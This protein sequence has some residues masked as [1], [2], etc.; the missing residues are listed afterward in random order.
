MT[1]YHTVGKPVIRKDATAKVL[2]EAVYT[3]DIKLPGLLHGK[4]LRSSYPHALIK[5]INTE[6]AK[7]VSGVHAVLT[8]KDIPGINAF[9]LAIADQPVLADKKVRMMGDAVA[10]VAAETEEIALEALDKIK[11]DYEPLPAYFT[12][13]D[14]LRED[15]IP[16]HEKEPASA[17]QS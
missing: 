7:A 9:G 6:K 8:A 10:L 17:Y 16:I 2:G 11:V 5:N 4:A 15:A 14:A 3:G 12:V 1:S 13:D